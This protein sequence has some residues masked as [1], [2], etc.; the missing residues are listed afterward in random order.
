MV[1]LLRAQNLLMLAKIANTSHLYKHVGDVLSF[2]F[3]V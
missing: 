2:A 3:D 1:S